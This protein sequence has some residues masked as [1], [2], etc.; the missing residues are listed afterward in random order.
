MGGFKAELE[1]TR[2]KDLVAQ[3]RK[4]VLK[5]ASP[6]V[7]DVVAMWLGHGWDA[8]GEWLG[9]GWVVGCVWLGSGW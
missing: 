1:G 8:I 9:R 6:G 2:A 5:W 4:Y 7:V 3:G